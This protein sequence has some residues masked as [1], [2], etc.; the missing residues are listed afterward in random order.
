MFCLKPANENSFCKLAIY[1]GN[2]WV[3]TSLWWRGMSDEWGGAELK[4]VGQKERKKI[5]SLMC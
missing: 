5:S 4:S 1:V 2:A 3:L